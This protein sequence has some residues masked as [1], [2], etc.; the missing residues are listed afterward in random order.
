MEPGPALAQ[1]ARLSK[2]NPKKFLSAIQQD[3]ISFPFTNS[4]A[5]GPKK[6]TSA[7]WFSTGK[8][9]KTIEKIISERVLPFYTNN[10]TDSTSSAR[11]TSI[12]LYNARLA[13]GRSIN[14]HIVQGHCHETGIIF[15]GDSAT[16]AIIQT[17]D[18][19]QLCNE[20][21]WIRKAVLE[22]ARP[23]NNYPKTSNQDFQIIDSLASLPSKYRPVIFVSAQGH[24]STL[25]PWLDSI[26]DVVIIREGIDYKLDLKHL[27]EQLVL[28]RDRPL[29]IGS[30]AAGSDMTGVLNDTTVI[31][32]VLHKHNAFAFFDY[33]TVGPFTSIDMNPH[34]STISTQSRCNLAYKDGVFL[35]PHRMMGGPGAS[36]VL[37]ARVDV[38]SWVELNG[39]PGKNTLPSKQTPSRTVSTLGSR[40]RRKISKVFDVEEVGTSNALGGI[41]AGLVFCLQ[42]IMNPI[43]IQ[44]ME[45]RLAA[46]I[47][48]RLLVNKNNI[49][50]HGKQGYD[51]IAVFCANIS[52]PQLSTDSKPLQIHYG[53]LSLIMNDFFGI[54]M[55][56]ESSSTGI[57]T[58]T[59][60]SQNINNTVKT[61]ECKKQPSESKYNSKGCVSCSPTCSDY[62]LGKPYPRKLQQRTK[63]SPS[64]QPGFIRFSFPHF[65]REKDVEFV[66]RSLE[67]VAEY[68]FLLIP[69]Y[70]LDALRGTWSIRPAVRRAIVQTTGQKYSNHEQKSKYIQAATDCIHQLKKL[71]MKQQKRET[72]KQSP[73]SALVPTSK[74]MNS[75]DQIFESYKMNKIIPSIPSLYTT[76]SYP[77]L[78][79]RSPSISPIPRRSSS[80][81]HASGLARTLARCEAMQYD[82]SFDHTSPEYT[83]TPKRYQSSNSAPKDAL[84]ELSWAELESEL[85]ALETDKLS[86]HLRWFVMPIDVAELFYS[87]IAPM[88]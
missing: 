38:F 50:I 15:C 52:V 69:L 57:S 78:P 61:S 40:T 63:T 21:F 86:K 24:Y 68:G 53:L 42:E 70:R 67:W 87:G 59:S 79:S 31:A 8:S 11:T 45:Y 75:V 66:L 77:Q 1:W 64:L 5:F 44:M 4:L 27:E 18:N 19:F 73:S 32:E 36:G 20:T 56:S 51:R 13:I 49:T 10:Y 30:I 22:G 58:S 71:F 23:D 85:S 25:Q 37:A 60:T 39:V 33:S 41:R 82:G 83:R 3:I 88:P 6:S 55:K 81:Y 28:Y 16:S 7:N 26:A 9:L 62:Q 46:E 12:A 54:E 84:D 47:F 14:A 76:P 43:L 65:T 74:I 48:H 29:K 35:S 2:K 72:A 17:R 34:P 80:F